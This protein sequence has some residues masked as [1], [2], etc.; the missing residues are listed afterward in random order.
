ME[1][2]KREKKTRPGKE[3]VMRKK[4]ALQEK[5]EAETKPANDESYKELVGKYEEQ[6]EEEKK[7]K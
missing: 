4:K 7:E 1:P 3:A 2:V 5:I 6:K